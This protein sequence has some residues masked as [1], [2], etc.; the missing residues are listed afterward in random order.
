[1]MNYLTLDIKLNEN[2]IIGDFAGKEDQ[3][4]TLKYIAGSAIRGA[5]IYDLLHKI[6]IK[7]QEV[8]E[9]IIAN[10]V[11][12]LN[13]YKIIENQRSIPTPLCFV[14]DKTKQ[15][16]KKNISVENVLSSNIEKSDEQR[17]RLKVGE[18]IKI[19]EKNI[20]SVPVS[21]RDFLHIK[22]AKNNPRKEITNE[23]SD[24]QMYRVESIKK[25]QIFR[26]YIASKDKEAIEL[27]EKS[28]FKG[29]I[30]YLGASRGNG[31]GQCELIN[32]EKSNINK[33]LIDLTEISNLNKDKKEFYLLY[34][35]DLIYLNS[36]GEVQGKFEL[37]YLKDFLKVDCKFEGIAIEPKIITGFNSKLGGRLPQYIGA[38]MG[39][40][41]KYSYSGEIEDKDLIDF[42][43]CSH[44][45]RIEEGFGRV[46]IL[47]DLSI[48][49]VLFDFCF[50]EDNFI[51]KI[52][53]T[54][55]EKEFI[56][57]IL[58][59]IYTYRLK[60]IF[61]KETNNLVS[62]SIAKLNKS[63]L[64]KWRKIFEKMKYMNREDGTK[65]YDE[66]INHIKESTNQNKLNQIRLINEIEVINKV[67]IDDWIKKSKDIKLLK[68]TKLIPEPITLENETYCLEDS[69]AYYWHMD[70]LEKIFYHSRNKKVGGNYDIYS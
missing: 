34:M 35:S 7:E 37:S 2:I 6:G 70:F 1:M 18:F 24:A 61:T 55:K 58:K 51:G 19:K 42:C 3:S 9:K 56:K 63:Q 53:L 60:N 54:E 52:K 14:A 69:E 17:V 11:F 32:V 20:V 66:L 31:Y 62:P 67:S 30:I 38:K 25:G 22:T 64:S 49:N 10:K 68:E 28:I 29:K 36:N 23:D 59:E 41:A 43:N 48:E 12:F 45:L 65:Y 26:A 4:S 50:V 44:G 39:T 46:A 15:R 27:I 33:E 5:V 21:T 57:I 8:L 13:G 40:I 16:I 47:N